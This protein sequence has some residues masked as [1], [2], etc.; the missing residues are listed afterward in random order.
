MELYI[1]KQNPDS[2][3]TNSDRIKSFL[4]VKVEN[5]IDEN[6]ENKDEN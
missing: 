6:S 3:K 1:M 2:V 4:E 5:K